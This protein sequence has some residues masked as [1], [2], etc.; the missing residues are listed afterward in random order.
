LDFDARDWKVGKNS[1]ELPAIIIPHYSELESFMANIFEQ[2]KTAFNY[3]RLNHTESLR[4]INNII[5]T[6]NKCE[7]V[8]SIN[9]IMNT[10]TE[11]SFTKGEKMQIWNSIKTKAES[12]GF[13]YDVKSKQ[14]TG[15]Q[16]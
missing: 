10:L 11:S 1:A 7:S 14:F 16:S 9:A 3:T 5:E 2:T 4:A 12:L 8:E 6:A 15:V 13:N